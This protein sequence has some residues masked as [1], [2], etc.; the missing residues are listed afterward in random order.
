MLPPWILLLGCSLSAQPQ[1][2]GI[3]GT[4]VDARGGEVLASVEI[5]ISTGSV[6]TV[7]NEKGH[8]RLTGVAPGD[9]VLNVATVG[10]HAARRAFHINAG[11]VAEMNVVLSPDTFHQTVAVEAKFDPF[12]PSQTDSP[13]ALVLGGNDMKNLASVLADDPLRSV[14]SLPGVSSNNDFDARF[15]LRGAGF[16]RIGLYLDGVLLHEPFHMIQGQGLSGTGSAF[17]GDIIDSMELHQSAFP[18]R[19]SDR[20]AGVL[21]VTMREGS[22]SET[23]FRLSASASEAGVQA[24]GP[25]GKHGSWLAVVRKSYLQYVLAR[26]FPDATLIFGIEDAQ[27]RLSYDL[28]PKNNVSLY[29]LESFSSL[30]RAKVGPTLGVDSV[31]AAGYHYTLGNAGWRYT[32]KD[33]LLFVNH[34]AWMREK[35]NDQ[36]PQQLPMS[37]GFY[38]EWAWN[39][40]ATWMW[41]PASLA[42]GRMVVTANAR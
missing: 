1:T 39:S 3:H 14:Q 30:D 22:R 12:E 29:V 28:T 36:N 41:S 24:E 17:D 27:T 15:S 21:D 42:T 6:K 4:V 20:S 19:F 13:S 7:T 31:L 16:D 34:L 18:A 40:S 37:G 26:T 35:F 11:E 32:P 9:Y 23:T 5:F 2:G 10:Y 25:L 33:R 8:F 38:N